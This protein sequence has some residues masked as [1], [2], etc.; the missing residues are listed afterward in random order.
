MVEILT[1][2][3]GLLTGPQTVDLRVAPS[4]VSVEITLDGAPLDTVY[5]PPWSTRLELGDVPQP[6]HL[7]ATAHGADGEVLGVDEAFIHLDDDV[8]HPPHGGPLNHRGP[9]TPVLIEPIDGKVPGAAEMTDWFLVDG[10]PAQIL[11]VERGPAE[12]IVVRD[13]AAQRWMELLAEIFL[14]EKMNL[15]ELPAAL[16]PTTLRLDRQT[17]VA[18]ANEVL[19][20]RGGPGRALSA[21]A[22]WDEWQGFL[23]LEDD[24]SIRFL[25]PQAAPASRV[26][27]RKQVFNN[28]NPV[29]ADLDGVL[30]HAARVR[31][32]EFEL[33]LADAVAIAGQEAFTTGRRRMVLLLLTNE[34]KGRSRFE[35][36]AIRG[37]LESLGVPL[38]AWSFEE[39][40]PEWGSTER[41]Q[42]ADP[43]K[44]LSPIAA[45]NFLRRTRLA[46]EEL[47]RQL[48]AQRVVW[49]DGSHLPQNITLAPQAHGIRKVGTPT[50]ARAQ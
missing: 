11:G 25:S 30:Y 7:V 47:N 45:R 48:E 29:S 41:L 5:G 37:Y 22:A 49:L 16:P 28:T 14:R 21:G 36:A 50:E 23:S 46:F 35:P 2:F 44:A 34:A 24:T 32:L 19:G 17:F 42:D 12:L 1:L 18:Q 43:R 8:F 39:R 3:L 9:R 26:A 38:A 40:L 10:E 27:G 33:R 31:P 6:H 13:P 4:V 20:T 15:R